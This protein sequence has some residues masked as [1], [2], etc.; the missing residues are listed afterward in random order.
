MK[1]AGQL[2]IPDEDKF[3]DDI[4]KHTGDKFSHNTLLKALEYVT[5]FTE[6]VDVG[7][8]VGSWTRIMADKFSRVLAFEPYTENRKCLEE[9]TR[10]LSNV[11]RMGCGLSNKEGFCSMVND[12]PENSGRWHVSSSGDIRLM[13]LDDF[14]LRNCNLLKLDVEGYEL[15]V[16]QGARSTIEKHHPIIVVELTGLS[17]RYG[18]TDDDVRRFLESLGYECRASIGK[19]HIYGYSP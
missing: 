13:P 18:V 5:D 2:Y 10:H 16:L 14:R 9:N 7:A 12:K 17:D 19:D 11:T 15:F 8:H 4:F 1:Q 6:A 3:F